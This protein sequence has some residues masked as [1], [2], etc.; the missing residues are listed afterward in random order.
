MSV[1]VCLVRAAVLLFLSLSLPL[2][3]PSLHPRRSL[4]L[5]NCSYT[6]CRLSLPLPLCTIKDCLERAHVRPSP[7]HPHLS[8]S[9]VGHGFFPRGEVFLSSLRP[10]TLK[11]QR[12]N[13]GAFSPP[14][15]SPPLPSPPSIIKRTNN[16]R[17]KTA[18]SAYLRTKEATAVT[19]A[20]E[21]FTWHALQGSVRV[22]L[23]CDL[24]S[25]IPPDPPSL[26][27]SSKS[28]SL[29]S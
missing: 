29:V 27:L 12:G 25:A 19:A 18:E 9:A 6:E 21:Q 8:G 3:P 2:L 20:V 15:P 16:T 5:T 11:K 23:I 24:L 7:T 14:L 4:C 26:S 1:C 10:H 13:T 28:L 22:V 17:H